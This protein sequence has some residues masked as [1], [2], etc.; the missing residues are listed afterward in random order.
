MD[1]DLTKKQN[2]LK[3]EKKEWRKIK[4]KLFNRSQFN[5]YK[6]DDTSNYY[7]INEDKSEVIIQSYLKFKKKESYSENEIYKIMEHTFSLCKLV[8]F[9]REI[10]E[11]EVEISHE[12]E[13]EIDEDID[14]QLKIGFKH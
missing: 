8:D 7:Q 6:I 13:D 3:I 11:S 5:K 14:D 2:K 1:F 9:I 4:K 12:I 10:I